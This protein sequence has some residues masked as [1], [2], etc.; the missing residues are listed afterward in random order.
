[1]ICTQWSKFYTLWLFRLPSQKCNITGI[2][3]KKKTQWAVEQIDT[4]ISRNYVIFCHCH[5]I[6]QTHTHTHSSVRSKDR[7]RGALCHIRVWQPN[8]YDSPLINRRWWII[9][10]S[11]QIRCMKATLQSCKYAM[12]WSSTVLL[13]L[14]VFHCSRLTSVFHCHFRSN[15]LY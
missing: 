15:F 8:L 5:K 14:F 7:R 10:N 3:M 4:Q 1:M 11:N 6:P 13:W 12:F 2:P 9:L